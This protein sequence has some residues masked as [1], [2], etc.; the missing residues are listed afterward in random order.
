MSVDLLTVALMLF[1]AILHAAWHGLVKSS[2]D[3]IVNLAGMGVV[4]AIP[5][6][7]LL[8]FVGLPAPAAWW[9]LIV[10]TGLHVAY[11]LCL[12]SAYARGDLGEAFPLARGGV[13]L[14]ALAIAFVTLGQVP[15][16][17]QWIA[18]GAISAG[19]L[20]IVAERLR[21]EVSVPLIVAAALAALA[22]ASYS[23][24]DAHGVQVA[25]NWV[26]FT[27]WLIV[28]DN[29]TFL[30]VARHRRGQGLWPALVAM[31]GR[32]I[33]SGLLG[34]LSF[35]VFLWALGRSPVAAVS[36]LR[37]TSVLFAILIGAML[38]RERW[39]AQRIAAGCLIVLGIGI[40][41]IY[42]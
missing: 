41:A 6:L 12:S 5:A 26:T 9:I 39:S 10:S 14:F 19:L 24:L 34:L 33:V 13:P 3:Q 2:D 37:E 23:V 16:A 42:R 15:T 18:I 32:V 17:P 29:M 31:R 36:A 30:A 40:I 4:A 25:G 7:A 11:K 22:V 35:S 20:L 8:P 38:H 28:L 1:A 21:G 27:A